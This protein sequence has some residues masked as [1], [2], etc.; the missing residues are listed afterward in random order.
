MSSKNVKVGK[1]DSIQSLRAIAFIGILSY[2]SGLLPLGAWGVSVFIV[3]SGFIMTY[4][5]YSRELEHSIAFNFMFA[6]GK[7]KKLY[8]LHVT[9]MLAVVLLT[10]LKNN[11]IFT[12][13]KVIQ[14]IKEIVLSVF[15][16][17]AWIPN[18]KYYYLL[19]GVAWYLCVCVILYFVF[20]WILDW[21]KGRE[22]I[23]LFKLGIR[24]YIISILIAIA[25]SFCDVPLAFSDDFSK[26]VTYICPAFRVSDFFIGCCIGCIFTNNEIKLTKIK[27]S[28]FESIVFV[29]IFVCVVFFFNQMLE[30]TNS[31]LIYSILFTPSSLILVLL[32][33]IKQGVITKILTNKLLVYIGNISSY[34]FL[35][36]QVVIKY[37]DYYFKGFNKYAKVLVIIILTLICSELFKKVENIVNNKVMDNLK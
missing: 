28:L 1:M 24:V 37:F 30:G 18:S 26:W 31:W 21:L 20:P 14:T 13:A 8:P 11:F 16:L 33:A 23:Y 5:Y 19:N 35:I 6:L 7:I 12:M 32:F 4:S 9:M 36:H 2:H 34:G 10:L 27:A 29:Y 17:Q 3:L 15:L 25:T 22:N